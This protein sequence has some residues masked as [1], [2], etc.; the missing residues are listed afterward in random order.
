MRKVMRVPRRVRRSLLLLVALG[1]PAA[2]CGAAVWQKLVVPES[3]LRKLATKTVMPEYPAATRERGVQGRA[4]AL[5]QFDEESNVVAVKILEAPDEETGKSVSDAIRKWKFVKASVPD[6]GGASVR[7][8][9]RLTF[10]FEI[11]DGRAMVR[12]PKKF[13]KPAGA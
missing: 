1:L 5:L 3:A 13:Q 2:V 7:M 11:I 9:S 6:A 12:P 10:Y 8:E 4:V